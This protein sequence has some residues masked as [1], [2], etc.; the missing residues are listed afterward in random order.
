[1]CQVITVYGSTSQL[2]S[3][4][5]CTENMAECQSEACLLF[6]QY[7]LIRLHICMVCASRTVLQLP[8]LLQTPWDPCRYSSLSQHL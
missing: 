2:K 3:L 4:F 5:E 1:M 7:F 8:Y 6:S